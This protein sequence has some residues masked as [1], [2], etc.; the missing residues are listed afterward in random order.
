MARQVLSEDE[1]AAAL[2]ELPGW[3][4]EEGW[5]HKQYKFVSF[6]QAMGWMMS[7]AI[8]ADKMDHHPTVCQ[9]V[10]RRLG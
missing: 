8:E 2:A 10:N 6:A 5:L 4:V 7:A 1:I 3:S 9:K